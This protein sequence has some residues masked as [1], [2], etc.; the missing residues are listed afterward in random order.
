MIFSLLIYSTGVFSE[1]SVAIV[2]F[3]SDKVVAEQTNK[4]RTLSRG[5]KLFKGD[6]ITTGSNARAQIKYTNGTIVSIEP[7]SQ[8]ETLSYAPKEETSL[9]MKLTSGEIKYDSHSK[10]KKKNLLQTNVVALSIL[11]TRF[12]AKVSDSKTYVNVSKGN[13]CVANLSNNSFKKPCIGPGQQILDGTFGANG[14]FSPGNSFS[15]STPT[16]PVASVSGVV[17]TIS[18][19]V[20]TTTVTNSIES[21]L[22]AVELTTGTANLTLI[23]P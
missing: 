20:S 19:T 22:P 13:V 6:S 2:L 21:V 4:Q 17:S 14:S 12:N 1:Q 3:A 9:T 16:A 5:S 15:A 7:N 23:S 18:Q 11:G 10:T 8:Y